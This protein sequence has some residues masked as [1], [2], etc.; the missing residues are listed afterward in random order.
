MASAPINALMDF[1][2]W[3]ILKAFERF[4]ISSA[5]LFA[6]LYSYY[7]PGSPCYEESQS[8]LFSTYYYA[9]FYFISL[10]DSIKINKINK[11]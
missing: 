9:I 2:E 3:S 8:G 4:K 7:K 10:I 11:Q 6:N 1:L 5:I